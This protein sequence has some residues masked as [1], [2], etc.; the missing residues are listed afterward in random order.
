LMLTGKVVGLAESESQSPAKAVNRLVN[1][2]SEPVIRKAMYQAM[3]IMGHQF[4]LGR[5]IGEAQK[6]GKKMRDRGFTYSYDMLGEAA[7]TKSDADKYF[8]D[9]LMAIEAV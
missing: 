4:V 2:F 9:Y 7:L 5:S 8:K 6:N 1:K 3:K